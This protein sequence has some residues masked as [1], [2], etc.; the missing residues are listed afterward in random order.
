MKNIVIIKV[1]EGRGKTGLAKNGEKRFLFTEGTKSAFDIVVQKYYDCYRSKFPNGK[2]SYKEV[3]SQF[4]KIVLKYQNK[5]IMEY[6]IKD[7]DINMRVGN[8]TAFRKNIPYADI[9]KTLEN[10]SI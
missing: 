2:L 10:F 7:I 8:L 6:E 3:K 9:N 1:V 4:I 5:E